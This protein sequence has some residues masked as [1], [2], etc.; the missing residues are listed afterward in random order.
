MSDTIIPKEFVFFCELPQELQK[1]IIYQSEVLPYWLSLVSKF[2]NDWAIPLKITCIENTNRMTTSNLMKVQKT[3]TSI[4]LSGNH[5]INDD[6]LKGC[7]NLTR[8]NLNGSNNITDDSFIEL[9]KFNNLNFVSLGCNSKITNNSICKLTNLRHL[10]LWSNKKITGEGLR[11]LTNLES[12]ILINNDAITTED[13]QVLVKFGKLKD[14]GVSKTSTIK[15]ED[16]KNFK[17][18]KF[19][20]W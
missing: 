15:V 8:L 11:H 6:Y 13:I 10:N 16:F 20:R 9:A 5:V 7:I 17:F 19:L 1:E 12:L 2:F 18:S 4:N 14:V 3:L